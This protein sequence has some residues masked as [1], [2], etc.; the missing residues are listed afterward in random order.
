MPKPYPPQIAKSGFIKRET[1]RGFGVYN[2]KNNAM[3]VFDQ[4][5]KAIG[6]HD[7]SQTGMTVAAGDGSGENSMGYDDLVKEK[8]LHDAF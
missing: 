7:M 4:P 3:V 1:K 2:R 6:H 5:L 8:A